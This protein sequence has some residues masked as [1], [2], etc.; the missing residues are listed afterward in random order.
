MFINSLKE[1][2]DR[3]KGIMNG[4]G[5]KFSTIGEIQELQ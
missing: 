5:K 2:L 1:V 4:A 3:R